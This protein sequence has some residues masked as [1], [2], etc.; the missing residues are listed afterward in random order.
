LIGLILAGSGYSGTAATQSPEAIKAIML[1]VTLLPAAAHLLVIPL[2][3]FYRLNRQRCAEI[4]QQLDAKALSA[5][6]QS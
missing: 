4:R 5:Q 1:S 3:S 2:V 6:S